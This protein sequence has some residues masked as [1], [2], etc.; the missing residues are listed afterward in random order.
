LEREDVEAI[1]SL[2]EKAYIE[3]IHWTQDRETVESVFHPDFNMLVLD[4]DELQKVTIGAAEGHDRRVVPQDR[5][6]EGQQPGSVEGRDGARVP[7]GGR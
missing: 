5:G 2:V 4:G 6:D 1:K 3:G 7:L